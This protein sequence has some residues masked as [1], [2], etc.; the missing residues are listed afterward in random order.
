LIR[1]WFERFFSILSPP[2]GLI[3]FKKILNEITEKVESKCPAGAFFGVDGV[4]EGIVWKCTTPGFESSNFWFK[5]KGNK[6]LKTK[7]R[8]LSTI[9]EERFNK[10][11]SLSEYLANGERLEQIAQEVFD[12]LNGGDFNSNKI[13][14]FIKSVMTDIFDEESDIISESGFTGKDISKPVSIICRNYVLSKI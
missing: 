4:G 9:D 7:V 2:F 10:I 5:V 6:H 3:G 8:T 1:P 13:G 11:K 12:L 14:L